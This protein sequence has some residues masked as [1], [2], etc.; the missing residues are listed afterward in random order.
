MW[1]EELEACLWERWQLIM[2]KVNAVLEA[3]KASQEAIAS[4]GSRERDEP[5]AAGRATGS[6]KVAWASFRSGGGIGGRPDKP[7]E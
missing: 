4:E 1:R 2:R 7:A 3:K 6:P 5:L